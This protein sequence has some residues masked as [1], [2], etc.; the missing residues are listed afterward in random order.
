MHGTTVEKKRK[1][2]EGYQGRHKG[3]YA[4]DIGFVLFYRSFTQ[5]MK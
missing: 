4:K 1:L 3:E 5:K 2:K